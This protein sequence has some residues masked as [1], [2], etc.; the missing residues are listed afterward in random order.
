MMDYTE[1]GGALPLGV[2]GGV[3]KAHGSS[4]AFAIKN[5]INQA[6]KFANGNVVNDIEQ[7]LKELEE[8]E[9]NKEQEETK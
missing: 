3:I 2:K 1:Y 8:K 5:A 7:V 9:K 4:N 6:I